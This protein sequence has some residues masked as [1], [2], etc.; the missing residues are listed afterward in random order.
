MSWVGRLQGFDKIDRVFG[1]DL[2]ASLCGSRLQRN[3]RHFLYGGEPGVAEMLK[4]KLE[5]QISRPANRRHV[6]APFS[7]SHG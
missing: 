6:Y 7:K 5:S 2:M 3:Y 1:P 4:Q